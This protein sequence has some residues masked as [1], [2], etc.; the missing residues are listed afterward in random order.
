ME[1][2]EFK[3]QK[4]TVFTAY[5]QVNLLLEGVLVKITREEE[6]TTGKVRFRGFDKEDN[7]LVEVYPESCTYSVFYGESLLNL[8]S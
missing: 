4:V 1:K 8:K 6:R 2:I 7:L 5:G 3:I